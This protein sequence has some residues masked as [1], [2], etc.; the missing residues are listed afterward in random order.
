MANESYYVEFIRKVWQGSLSA[1]TSQINSDVRSIANTVFLEIQKC[2]KAFLALDITYQLFYTAS[3]LLD[4]I[5]N[6]VSGAITGSISGWVDVILGNSQYRTCIL[7]AALKWKSVMALALLGLARKSEAEIT[8]YLKANPD[9]CVTEEKDIKEVLNLI[10]Q[11][12]AEKS[13]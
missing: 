12:P 9:L 2:S 3:G 4:V 8:E 10:R 5:V 1:D 11:I 13:E 6:I 7:T